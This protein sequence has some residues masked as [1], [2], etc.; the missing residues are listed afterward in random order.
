MNDKQTA[1]WQLLSNFVAA[2]IPNLSTREIIKN[3]KTHSL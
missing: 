1:S 3:F 2:S